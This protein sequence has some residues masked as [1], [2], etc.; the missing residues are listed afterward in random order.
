[1][2]V[3]EESNGKTS[4]EVKRLLNTGDSQDRPIVEGLRK[5]IAAYGITDIL[6]YHE[7][8]RRAT[9]VDFFGGSEYSQP[10]PA[11]VTSVVYSM[12]NW[13]LRPI[14]T[15]YVCRVFDFPVDKDRHII[16]LEAVIDP[17]TAA[18]V[19]HF[20]VIACSFNDSW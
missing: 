13:S 3:G 14:P 8:N 19:H 16:K 20:G 5:V 11:N 18:F 4:V 17:A 10:L 6:Q 15:D 1:M 9:A 12:G 2:H 7:T